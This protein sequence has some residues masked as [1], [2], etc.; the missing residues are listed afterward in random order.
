MFL[1]PH[2]IAYAIRV[3]IAAESK[4]SVTYLKALAVVWALKHF[5]DI[6]FGYPITVHTDPIAVTQLFHGKNFTGRRAR[7][8]LTMQQFEPTFKPTQLQ[9]PYP[10]TS[11][12]LQTTRLLTFPHQNFTS[13]NA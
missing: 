2:V 5:R 13:P 12:L 6:I 9:M 4:Y 11:Q 8:Y 3:L 7:W 10:A 1:L